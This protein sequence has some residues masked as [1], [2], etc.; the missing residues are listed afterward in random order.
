MSPSENILS[1]E[2]HTFLKIYVERVGVLE[3]SFSFT[4]GKKISIAYREKDKDV[5]LFVRTSTPEEDENLII[6]I[7]IAAKY[8]LLTE[9]F[10]F[11][12]IVAYTAL[13]IL[14]QLSSLT[15]QLLSSCLSNLS[16]D[17]IKLPLVEDIQINPKD[18]KLIALKAE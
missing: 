12:D 5:Q 9:Q 10:V 15:N 14:P 1:Y 2:D 11:E 18:V 8:K 4:T 16:I 3:E 13:H 6:D 17:N 7:L